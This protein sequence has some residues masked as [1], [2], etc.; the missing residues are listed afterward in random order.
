VRGAKK[1]AGKVAVFGRL[2]V[3]F[4]VVVLL[5]L[6]LLTLF[7]VVSLLSQVS[8]RNR[9]RKTRGARHLWI[10]ALHK[11]KGVNQDLGILGTMVGRDNRVASRTFR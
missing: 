11:G 2:G 3:L 4:G 10:W 7:L 9:I 6:L 5:T 1:A 8:V